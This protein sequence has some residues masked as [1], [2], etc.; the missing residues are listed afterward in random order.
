VKPVQFGIDLPDGPRDASTV[1]SGHAT[2]PTRRTSDEAFE[3][4]RT[5]TILG[6]PV[7]CIY[8]AVTIREEVIGGELAKL[9]QLGV[10]LGKEA[11]SNILCSNSGVLS[12]TYT[13]TPA[14]LFIT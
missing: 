4:T 11:G 13:I 7:K 9:D 8:S 14:S 1:E 5:C 10:G 12:A 2:G 6:S 3:D